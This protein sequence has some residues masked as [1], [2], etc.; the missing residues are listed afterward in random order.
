MTPGNYMYR[1]EGVDLQNAFPIGWGKPCIFSRVKRTPSPRM[2]GQARNEF[3]VAVGHG[4]AWASVWILAP[5]RNMWSLVLRKDVREI[6]LKAQ[7]QMSLEQGQQYLRA[8]SPEGET[9]LVTRG[10]TGMLAKSFAMDCTEDLGV[11]LESDAVPISRFDSSI[12][13][14]TITAET[15]KIC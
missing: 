13:Y 1:T 14:D 7:K 11:A 15:I 2:P 4:M 10:D 9:I 12:S 6:R 5:G 8:E 3:R